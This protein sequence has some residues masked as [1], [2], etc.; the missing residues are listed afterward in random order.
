MQHFQVCFGVTYFCTSIRLTFVYCCTETPQI[1]VICWAK[2]NSRNFLFGLSSNFANWTGPLCI[3]FTMPH[4]HVFV[5]FKIYK[6]SHNQNSRFNITLIL[7][8][9]WCTMQKI[10]FQYSIAIENTTKNQSPKFSHPHDGI[11]TL[12]FYHHERV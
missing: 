11:H 7:H 8:L 4:I 5:F 1:L 10:K 2:Q 3:Y 12:F 9:I 6:S